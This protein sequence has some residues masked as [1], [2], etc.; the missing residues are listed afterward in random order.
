M[1]NQNV[2]KAKFNHLIFDPIL[3]RAICAKCKLKL[4]MMSET[5]A[6]KKYQIT[7]EDIEA[8]GLKFITTPCPYFKNRQMKLFYEFQI[9]Q[10][11][12]I[13][14]ARRKQVKLGV[15]KWKDDETWEK[16]KSKRSLVLN[17]LQIFFKRRDKTMTKK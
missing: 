16:L 6:C 8:V 14:R 4:K 15:K 9:K 10:N 2:N 3:E 5:S 11:M 1:G 13:I 12:H 7:K 17:A